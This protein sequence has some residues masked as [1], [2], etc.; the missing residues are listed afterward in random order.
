MVKEQRGDVRLGLRDQLKEERIN[1]DDL[2]KR[3]DGTSFCYCAYVLRI[4][5]GSKKR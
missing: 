5:G 2:E 1:I 3:K 4:S